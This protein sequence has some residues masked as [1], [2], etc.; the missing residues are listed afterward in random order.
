MTK[1]KSSLIDHR[2]A[3]IEN[4]IRLEV[5]EELENVKEIKKSL[6]GLRMRLLDKKPEPFSPAD[7]MYAFFAALII[8]LGFIFKGVLVQYS[9]NLTNL[10]LNMIIIS[11]II[12]LTA[13]AYYLGYRRVDNKNERKM[14][15]FLFKRVATFYLISIIVSS[16]LIFIF[17]VNN[18]PLVHNDPIII[19]KIIITLTMPCATGAAIP[20]ILKKY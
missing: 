20:S 9:I 3:L 4:Q 12:L 8:G 18:V 5:E 6:V 1:R 17:G 16:F 15:Q 14:G 11:T 7:I 2:R 10:H 13:E 19:Y